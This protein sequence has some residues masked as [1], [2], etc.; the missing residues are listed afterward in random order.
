MTDQDH[1]A[2]V[3]YKDFMDERD[4]RYEER[5]KA[6][7]AAV[8]VALSSMEKITAATFAS[9]EKAIDK[10]E[11]AQK[12]KNEMSN[13]FRGQLRDQADRFMPRLEAESKQNAMDDK[14]DA[15]REEVARLREYRSQMGGRDHQQ[16]AA[17]S[18]SNRATSLTSSLG[19][20]ATG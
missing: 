19:S 14:I 4:R 2:H 12:D 8:T 9:S 7:E 20:R 15:L 11:A 10:A 5:F 3:T 18:Q 16:E 17:R 13:E 6:Q 1:M